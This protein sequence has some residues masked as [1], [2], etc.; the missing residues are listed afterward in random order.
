MTAEAIRW[1][2][3]AGRWVAT[4]SGVY[5]T[6]DA[7]ET[8]SQRLV[9]AAL[10]AGPDAVISHTTA[11]R[12]WDLDLPDEDPKRVHV[13]RRYGQS[14]RNAE[15]IVH[16]TRRLDA[17]DRA[18]RKGVPVTAVERT[19]VDLAVLLNETELEAALESALR[20]GL[21]FD[22]RLWRRVDDLWGHPRLHVLRHLLHVRQKKPAESVL[23]VQVERFLRGYGIEGFIRQYEVWDGEQW[24][25]LDWARPD[26]KVALEAESWK[27]HSGRIDWSRGHTRNRRLI[28]LGWR[29]IPITRVCLDD[30]PAKTAREI[31][32][33]CGEA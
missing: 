30:E 24:R 15:L 21:T 25:R 27:Y 10:W 31:L 3:D 12:L 32:M 6:A 4:L 16:R 23:E 7:P 11:G 14:A 33:A 2:R 18:I 22:E 26:T 20:Q 9:I 28:A 29:I 13:L 5:R 1:Q 19:L 17:M 8:P